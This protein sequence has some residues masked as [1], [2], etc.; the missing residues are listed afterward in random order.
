MDTVAVRGR[1]YTVGPVMARACWM[2]TRCRIVEVVS[3]L[4]VPV[5]PRS[6]FNQKKYFL[7]K[8]VVSFQKDQNRPKK[9]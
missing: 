4:C 5:I 1:L 2:W 6:D 8:G 3:R 9:I 7:K